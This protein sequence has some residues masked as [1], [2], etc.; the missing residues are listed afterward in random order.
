MF[1][2]MVRKI[3]SARTRNTVP[4]PAPDQRRRAGRSR[5]D[6]LI[7]RGLSRSLV[8]TVEIMHQGESRD[9]QESRPRLACTP[10]AWLALLEIL[11][12]TCSL[13]PPTQVVPGSS[14]PLTSTPCLRCSISPSNNST[15]P[16]R[17][18]S[19]RAPSEVKSTAF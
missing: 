5:L 14:W 11:E 6:H 18:K 9:L 1:L 17:V 19:N 4:S 16:R 7:Q 12:D 3:Q 10:S 15:V 13:M 8:P 2:P